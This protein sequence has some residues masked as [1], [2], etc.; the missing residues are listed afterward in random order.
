MKLH[1][2][3]DFDYC[4]DND[5]NAHYVEFDCEGLLW[6]IECSFRYLTVGEVR[7]VS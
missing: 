5:G 1:S 2:G 4:I 6:N 3:I 7:P